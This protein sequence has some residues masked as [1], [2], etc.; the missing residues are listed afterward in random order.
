MIMAIVYATLKIEILTDPAIIPLITAGNHVAAADALNV[1]RPALTI[2]RDII[3]AYELFE[4]INAGEYSGL[5]ATERQRLQTILGMGQV[6]LKGDN[7]RASLAVMFGP[8][9]LTR[10][11]IIALIDRQGSRAEQLFGSGTR[12]TPA[13]IALALLA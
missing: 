3:P 1:I 5:T 7:T 13:D 6:N 10:A 12:I 4:A 2:R 9:T 11:A 8:G